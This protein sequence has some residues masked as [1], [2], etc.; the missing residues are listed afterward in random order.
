MVSMVEQLVEHLEFARQEGCYSISRILSWSLRAMTEVPAED[1]RPHRMRS[2][3]EIG[4][5]L[6]LKLQADRSKERG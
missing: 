3:S 4:E 2:W 6:D 1:R 5:N